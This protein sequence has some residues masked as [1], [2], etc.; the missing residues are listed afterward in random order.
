VKIKNRKS[1]P[2]YGTWQAML[3]RCRN[4]NYH[5]YS[6]YG[7]RGIEVCDRWKGLDGFDN[8]VDDVGARP[9]RGHS[10]DRIDNDGNYEL[11]NVRWATRIEQMRNTE[12]Y[13]GGVLY[14]KTKDKWVVRVGGHHYG[15]YE[16]EREA[17]DARKLLTV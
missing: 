16:S 17:R 1:H 5:A 13:R 15:Q 4:K 11:G 6:R 7:G 8:F 2:L 14:W 3:N 10:L 9:S 12:K